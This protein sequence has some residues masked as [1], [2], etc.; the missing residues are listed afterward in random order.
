MYIVF[1]LHEIFCRHPLG[2]FD[3]WC[4]L[5]LGFLCWLFFIWMN[6]LLETEQY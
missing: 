4:H 3:L 6:H 5:V 2:P 1:L